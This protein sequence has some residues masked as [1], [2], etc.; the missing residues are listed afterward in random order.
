MALFRPAK[1]IWDS[2]PGETLQHAF[3]GKD[4]WSFCGKWHDKPKAR[5]KFAGLRDLP[6]CDE[7]DEKAGYALGLTEPPPVRLIEHTDAC[8][9]LPE[10]GDSK[11]TRKEGETFDHFMTRLRAWHGL[12]K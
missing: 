5:K 10:R 6:R 7:C 11:P 9:P 2:F 1:I 8:P 3:A 4:R 12:R